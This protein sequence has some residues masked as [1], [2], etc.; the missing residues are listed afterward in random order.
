MVLKFNID[1]KEFQIKM[2]DLFSFGNSKLKKGEK[3]HDKDF[4]SNKN[5]QL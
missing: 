2:Y 4:K 1:F 3:F 5:Q